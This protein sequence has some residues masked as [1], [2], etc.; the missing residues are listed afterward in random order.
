MATPSEKL[1]DSLEALK[2]LQDAGIVAVRSADEPNSSGTPAQE[3]LFTG[4]NEGL[5]CP[6]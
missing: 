2:E 5:V 6:V 3:R 1:A 4:S